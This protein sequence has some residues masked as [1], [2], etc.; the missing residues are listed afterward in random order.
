MYYS[1][2]FSKFIFQIATC[3]LA[4]CKI[5]KHVFLFSR[6]DKEYIQAS[7]MLADVSLL[8]TMGNVSC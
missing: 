6:G 1:K 7:Q 5:K 8:F 4:T 2:Q 3:Y